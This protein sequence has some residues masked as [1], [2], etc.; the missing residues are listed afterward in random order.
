MKK[1]VK[2][3][4]R[5]LVCAVLVLLLAFGCWTFG[6]FGGTI[7][8]MDFSADE[9]ETLELFNYWLSEHPVV[10]TEQGDIQALIDEINGFQNTG[11]M[12]KYPGK[13]IPG[14]GENWYGIT[15]YLA[16]GEVYRLNL[17]QL[18]S[19]VDLSD[20]EMRYGTFRTCRGSM[21]LFYA[22]HAKYLAETSV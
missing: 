7:D 4:R 21:E 2:K 8:V 10:I 5:P 22:L 3:N 12:L 1:F 19:R 14:G 11:T 6:W 16:E 13:L 17:S 15:V 9:V 20:M 18:D